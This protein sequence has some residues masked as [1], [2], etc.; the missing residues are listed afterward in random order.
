MRMLDLFCGEGLAAW[1]YWRS[2]RFSEIVGVDINPD[3]LHRYA[4]DRVNADA[5][6]LDYD[7]LL[8]FDFIHASP[9][10]QGYSKQTP[11]QSKHPRLIPQVHRMLTAAGK[12]YVIEN[13]EGASRDVRPNLV[14][15]GTAL[16]LDSKRRRYFHLSTLKKATR[17]LS[18]SRAAH[19]QGDMTRQEAIYSMGLD[20]I[21]WERQKR[22]TLGG[23]EQGIPPQMA[24]VIAQIMFPDYKAM[25]PSRARE[26][27]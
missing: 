11:D 2:G 18:S 17:I 8:S 24:L 15:D 27:D 3:V 10:C 21:P 1:G 6:T 19:V 9:P 5:L 13:V 22:L 16:G 25:I 23:M 7:F 20:C 12:P 26:A 4:F 14:M